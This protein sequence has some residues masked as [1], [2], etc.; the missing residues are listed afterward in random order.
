[1]ANLTQEWDVVSEERKGTALENGRQLVVYELVDRGLQFAAVLGLS[2]SMPKQK[3]SPFRSRPEYVSYA[4]NINP[5]PRRFSNRFSHK[6]NAH[7]FGIDFN[8]QFSI[9]NAKLL[10]DNLKD[11][12]LRIVRNEIERLLGSEVAKQE[13]TSIFQEKQEDN[14]EKLLKDITNKKLEY[15]SNFSLKYG[16]EIISIASSLHLDAED[17]EPNVAAAK[18]ENKRKLAEI[19]TSTA[20]KNLETEHQI[21]IIQENYRLQTEQ[22]KQDS[23][24]T[25]VDKNHKLQIL[26]KQHESDM[27]AIDL[28]DE[29][30][31]GGIDAL[32]TAA[33]NVANNTNT[34]DGIVAAVR[35]MQNLAPLATTGSML[36]GQTSPT[37]LLSSPSIHTGWAT[38]LQEV[39]E[40]F[41]TTSTINMPMRRLLSVLLHWIAEVSLGDKADL[42][43]LEEYRNALREAKQSNE[44]LTPQQIDYLYKSLQDENEFRQRFF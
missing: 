27:I 6:S 19:E 4:V 26:R 42:K 14:G 43:R 28:K 1:M 9:S 12:P 37:G 10:V 31:K 40:H 11:D 18:A 29:L 2:E 32:I 23:E 34:I 5:P 7:M 15:L 41:A 30:R 17:E 24:L 21:Q 20:I 39:L 35:N 22:I 33:A 38:V 25:L 16:V 13:W 44:D 36:P 3:F 8:M